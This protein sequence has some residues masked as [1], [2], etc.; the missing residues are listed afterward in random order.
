MG[1]LFGTDGVRGV[2]NSELTCE[3]A[4]NIGRAAAM[5]LLDNEDTSEKPTILIGKDTRIS[6]DMLEGALTAG[7]CSVGANVVHLGT[8]PTPAVA[9][10]VKKYN[11]N[12]G[13]MISAS[14]NPHE[15]NGI[16]IFNSDGYK[17]LDAL[18][19]KIEALINGECEKFAVPVGRNLGSVRT[20]PEAIDEYIDHIAGSIEGSLEGIKV[21]VDCSNGS[22]SATARRLFTKLG[23]DFTI[24]NDT[25]DGIN[26]NEK[27]GSTHIEGLSDFV[28][29]HNMDCGV[30][31]DGD[32]DRCLAVDEN[33]ELVDGDFLI[34]ICAKA[35]K[36]IGKLSNNTVVG[37]VMTN[38]GFTKFCEKNDIN[39]IS[40]S[41]GDRYVLENMLENNYN[42][43]GEQSGHIIFLDYGTTGDGQL[44]SV[45]LLSIIKKSG[46]TLSQL[47]GIMKRYP[48]VLINVKVATEKKDQY[49]TDNTIKTEIDKVEEEL[50]NRGRIL[51]RPSGTEPLIRVML[52]GEDYSEISEHANVVADL[53]RE[54][55]S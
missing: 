17:L 39:F 37:T 20:A 23:A 27:C 10:L 30:A 29:A 13:I 47:A 25:P 22:A 33:G 21:A 24:I 8:V 28:K 46:K 35:L 40:T 36:D 43:G 18:E 11:A 5:V 14:H 6:S 32:A 15:F 2:A 7:L 31:Y 49:F 48:Q 55:L 3:L 12:A 16:K 54:R 41:V 4:M 51:V 53:I 9:Y 34:A 42:I 45:Q 44:T 50:S 19:D 26:I 52:E 38:M 1:R